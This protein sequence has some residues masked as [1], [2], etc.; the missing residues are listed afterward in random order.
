VPFYAHTLAGRDES[1]WER[2]EDHLLEV[3]ALSEEFAKE[4]GAGDWGKSAGAWHD[5]GKYSEEFQKLL[6]STGPDAAEASEAPGRVDH[7]T[8]GAQHAARTLKGIAGQIIAF[9]IAGHHAGLTDGTTGDVVNSGSTLESRLAK[10]L[11]NTTVPPSAA[12]IGPFA[13]PFELSPVNAGFEIAFFTRMV[14]SCLVDADRTCTERFCDLPQAAL[15]GASK[16]DIAELAGAL[17]AHLAE[18]QSGAT[19]TLVNDLRRGVLADCLSAAPLA[20]GF[21][22]LNVPTGGGK[23]LSS[24][25]F[26]LR[27]AQTHNLRRVVVAIP[28]TSIIEQT[29]DTY[30]CA[31]GS[32]ADLA[33][34]EHHTNFDLRK[35]TRQHQLATENWDVP[36]VVTT[37]V[38]LFESLFAAA[39]TPCRKLHRLARSVIVLDEAQTLPVE[40]LAPTLAALKE[41]VAHYG[42]TVVLCTASQ[43]ALEFHPETFPIGIPKP[44]PIVQNEHH[45]FTSLN[46]T[47]IAHL[48]TLADPELVGRL[49]AESSVLCIV[50]T[51]P[52]AAQLHQALVAQTNP[53]H[54]FHLSTFMCPAHRRETL[55]NIRS[56]LTSKLPTRIISTQLI[57]AG[58]DIDLPAVYRAAAGFD[59]IAQA[60]GRCNREGLLPCLGRV[61]LFISEKPPPPGLLRSAA[62]CA[63][64]LTPLHPDPTTPSA[65]LA[66]FAQFYWHQGHHRWDKHAIL[67]ALRFDHRPQLSLKFKQVARDYKLIEDNQTPILVPHNEEAIHLLK[68]FQSGEFNFDMLRSAQKYTVSVRDHDLAR[69]M[70]NTAIVHDE[71]SGLYLLTNPD[72]YSPT[73]GL[74][75][76]AAGLDP[77]ALIQ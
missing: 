74:L 8:F 63:A 16:P 52:H 66:Y 29:A 67:P 61:Y 62:A 55:A 3:A 22:A 59:S 77:V 1:H 35:G 41:L 68:R 21:F 51:R 17:E 15:R 23:T 43:P 36:L 9:C 38:Q 60:A 30:R 39:T 13:L 73:I 58:V 33:I 47:T 54:C 45:L 25:A 10:S 46:R 37:N 19:R 34:V 18:K 31:L 56:R 70:E 69:L 2:L 4:F 40:M 26:A 20:P 12:T 24:L 75:T 7:S 32:L 57:E 71:I 65:I 5:L 53:H 11:P 50:N 6:R 28:Y 72:G 64:E 14:F 44:T 49:V 76:N 42:C 48:G 27:H